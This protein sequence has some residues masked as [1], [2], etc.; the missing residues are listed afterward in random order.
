VTAVLRPR[1]ELGAPGLWH[2]PD[3]TESRL[4]NGLRLMT[5]HRPGKQIATVAVVLDVPAD[6]DPA[7]L[8]GTAALAARALNEGTQ[9][10]SVDEFADALERH[11]AGFGA[12]AGYSGL[13]AT[14]DVPVT[15]LESA[16]GLLCEA[17][18]RPAFEP[19][20]V[21][22]VARQRL[23]EI[24]RERS[25]PPSRASVEFGAALHAAGTRRATPVA[26]TETTVSAL[27]AAE[28]AA[29][30]NGRASAA[31]S[32]VLVAGDLSGIDVAALVEDGLGAWTGADAGR[33][34]PSEPSVVPGP[35]AVVVDRPD[36]VQTQVVIG[37][38]APDRRSPRWAAM[39]LA[40][41]AVGGTL[42]S[43]IDAVL[44]EEKGYTYGMRARFAPDRR[45]G[46]FTVSGS[47]DTANTGPALDDL[48]RIL[49]GAVDEG[50]RQDERDAASEFLA[51]VS[52]TRWETPD[53]LVRQAATLVGC[54]LPVSW[55]NEYLRGL[56][57]A[58]LDEVNDALRAH[59]RP[60]ELVVVAVGA[61]DQITA[62][63]ESLGFG[64]AEVLTA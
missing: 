51:G 30:Y 42:T 2:F 16:F 37:H 5:L 47:F 24:V 12:D 39:A 19:G 63:L 15:R 18:T 43:R 8:E 40:A 59:V 53:S 35:R 33:W 45:G 3:F 36:A 21:D 28:V 52:P 9:D 25:N 62:P 49:R 64:K 1:P 31:G 13:T 20:E 11:G 6:A 41:Y 22:R 55:V 38:G 7:G 14:L 50:L 27:T 44:R 58:S 34:T 17:V 57:E 26:G 32:T 10:R 54:D 60:D 23:A 56:R 29:H 61:A 48:A 4:G 46:T